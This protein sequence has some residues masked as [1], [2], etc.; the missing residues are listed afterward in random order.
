MTTV[1]LPNGGWRPRD[2]QWDVWEYLRNGGKRALLF[3]HRRS[4][5][6]DVALHFGAISSQ[7]RVGNYWHMLP[8]QA[9]ARKA[10]WNAVNPKTGKRRIDD[11]FPLAMRKR[12]LD[13]E[14][15]IEMV[16]GSTWQVL[17]SDNY[18]SLVG[19]N[20]V[21]CTF[22]EWALC[23]PRA[24]AYISPI[25][26][27]NGGWAAFITTARG[28]N[29]AY[30]MY[31]AMRKNPNW[32]CQVLDANK[33]G[34]FSQEQ[35]GDILSELQGLHGN[36]LGYA[37]YSQE[38]LSSFD[39]AVVGA[40]YGAEMAKA[41]TDGRILSVPYSREKP[42]YTIWDIGGS[43]STSIWFVQIVG[44]EVRL[45]DYYE[46][47]LKDIAH[48]A[49]VLRERGYAYS[50][51]YLPHDAF[52]RGSAVLAV[53]KTIAQLLEGFEFSVKQSPKLG[54]AKQAGIQA[55]RM[56]LSRCYFDE[57]KTA[58]GVDCLTNYRY[59]DS[60]IQGELQREP[61]HDWA[62]HGADAFG[63]IAMVIDKLHGTVSFGGKH[64]FDSKIVRK[65]KGRV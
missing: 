46:N 59:D 16:N 29:H 63:Y 62:S 43:D 18:D 61:L 50:D 7:L 32:F 58:R 53:G 35:L 51:C 20:P 49:Q 6:D 55:A 56:M 5:K 40:V 48:Y 13:N 38:Y 3:W 9:Q 1:T 65:N 27:E 33:T 15:L 28:K 24:W 22:S 21:G 12:T 4:G 10:I 36:E 30:N 41:R 52:N 31:Q 57:T 17:G 23:D 42:V 2:Y 44:N 64:T 14:M 34:I 54:T 8:E 19:S 60:S 37:L 26:E 45:I 11:A 25:L 47:R 39:A